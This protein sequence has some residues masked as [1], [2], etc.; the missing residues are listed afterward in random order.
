MDALVGVVEVCWSYDFH[1]T[2]QKCARTPYGLKIIFHWVRKWCNIHIVLLHFNVIVQMLSF[3]YIVLTLRRL[4]KLR[5][6]CKYLVLWVYF[7]LKEKSTFRSVIVIHMQ[8]RELLVSFRVS[9]WLSLLRSRS[10]KELDMRVRC[11]RFFNAVMRW[12]ESQLAVLLRWSQTLR[13]AMFVFF[14]LRCSV[15]K[16]FAVL[17]CFDLP[18]SNLQ[19][20]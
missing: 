11:W 18:L 4:V 13:C 19:F 5:H 3:D 15:K 20:A 8:A 16:L 7:V 9:F 2:K 14:T 10:L 1:V 6:F 12:I 17:G